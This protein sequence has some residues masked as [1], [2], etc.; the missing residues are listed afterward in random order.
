MPVVFLFSTPNVNASILNTDMI[1]Q[2]YTAKNPVATV[3]WLP[4][5]HGILDKEERVA[6]FLAQKGVS[7]VM[8]DLFAS[9]FLPVAPSSLQKIPKEDL[10]T[11][12]EELRQQTK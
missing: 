7:V 5:E 1:I 4:S 8:P 6:K 10:V 2:Y 12:I 9:Y 3:L 11:L